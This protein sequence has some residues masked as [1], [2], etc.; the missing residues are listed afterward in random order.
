MGIYIILLLAP[1]YLGYVRIRV[2]VVTFCLGRYSLCG[3]LTTAPGETFVVV[4]P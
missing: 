2:T 4:A 1:A 3:R